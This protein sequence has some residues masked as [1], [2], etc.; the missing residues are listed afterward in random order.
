M[1]TMLC[2]L[3]AVI[4]VVSATAALAGEKAPQAVYGL[5][6]TQLK[7]L[8]QDPAIL[9]AVKE[10]NAKGATLETDTLLRMEAALRRSNLRLDVVRRFRKSQ[11]RFTEQ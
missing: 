5:A 6:G 4:L 3:T 2:L 7:A 8:A 10:Q 11:P 9:S 1:R